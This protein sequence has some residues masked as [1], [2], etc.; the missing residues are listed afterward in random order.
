MNVLFFP[1]GTTRCE[2]D[3]RS[4]DT[5][6]RMDTY[7]PAE[8]RWDARLV[9]PQPLWPPKSASYT[10]SGDLVSFLHKEP[11]L[12]YLSI[13]ILYYFLLKCFYL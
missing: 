6:T 10:V 11:L 1:V 9:L 2:S 13:S 7:K 4:R 12:C 5:K 8:P 3:L